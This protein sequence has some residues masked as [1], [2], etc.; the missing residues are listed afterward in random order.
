[1]FHD[2]DA[3]RRATQAAAEFETQ[4]R[5]Q[6]ERAGDGEAIAAPPV[7]IWVP[8]APEA[9]AIRGAA[10]LMDYSIQAWV[11]LAFPVRAI[12]VVPYRG[13]MPVA[14]PRELVVVL[15]SR[16]PGF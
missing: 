4:L 8:A 2:Y 15:V 14:D 9:P 12:R 7:P 6:I 5:A 1:L 10:I 16:R 3:W 11:E 13:Q